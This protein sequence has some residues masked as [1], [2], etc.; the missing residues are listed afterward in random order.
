[1][2]HHIS[3]DRAVKLSCPLVSTLVMAGSLL[4]SI[5]ILPVQAVSAASSVARQTQRL[6][7]AQRDYPPQSLIN[8]IRQDLARRVG[9]QPQAL[10]VTEATR[11]TWNNG[12]LGLAAPGEYCTQALIDGWRISMTD[13]TQIWT[14]RTDNS[15][16]AIR[17]EP[18]SSSS[19]SL[20][21]TISDRVLQAAAQQ[22]NIP[23]S[24]LHVVSATATTWPDTCLGLPTPGEFCAQTTVNGWRVEVSDG[25]RHWFY[26]TN[27]DGWSVRR[28]TQTGPGDTTEPAEPAEPAGPAGPTNLPP[29]VRD[30]LLQ[31]AAQQLNVP[32]SSLQIVGTTAETWSDSCLGLPSAANESC[33]H[34]GQVT[35][36]RVALSNGNQ[37][38]FYRVSQDGR[39]IR[40]ETG[41][42]SGSNNVA[43]P[44]T[45]RDRVLR[46]ASQQSGIPIYRLKVISA[47]QQVWDGC[48]GIDPAPG[49]Y[50]TKIAIYGWRV[51]VAGDRQQWVYHTDDDGS[52]IRLSESN[53]SN[54]P[55]ESSRP[56]VAYPDGLPTPIGDR[57]LQSVSQQAGLPPSQ[58]HIVRAEQQT[59][60]GCL[61]LDPGPGHYCTQ[62]AIAGWRVVVSSDQ[63]Y[64][65]YHTNQDG[66]DIR[67]NTTASQ[68]GTGAPPTFIPSNQQVLPLPGNVILRSIAQGGYA[69]RTYETVLLDDGRVIRVW[70]NAPGRPPQLLRRIPPPQ[71]QQFEQ[72]LQGLRFANLDGLSYAAPPGSADYLTVTMTTRDGTTQYADGR[73][74]QLPTAMQR[75]IQS[76]NAIVGADY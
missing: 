75:M 62:Q 54:G 10:R 12:C 2:G 14:F 63:R 25:S 50:C 59:W 42:D 19:S 37:R 27:Q 49:Q 74:D 57:I 56:P 26:H 76:W 22:L 20:P 39:L 4:L 8:Q 16:R 11:Q 21:R 7:Q 6:A 17:L 66:S 23:I 33:D 9:I 58:L 13:G 44:Q 45:V 29:S 34:Q 32:L 67:L 28:E 31:V 24:R 55:N 46:V 35:G 18:Q 61:G 73:Q 38:W 71:V 72:A 47:E 36:W 51:V 69:G 53:E 1:M 64:W 48:L 65:V 68:G 30:R 70:R 60:D 15:G 5:S 40:W 43:L 3:T 52:D 41:T